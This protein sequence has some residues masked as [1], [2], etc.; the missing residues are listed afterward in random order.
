MT[1]TH[2]LKVFDKTNEHSVEA[3]VGFLNENNSITICLN[4]AINLQHNDNF[5]ITLFP[6]EWKDKKQEDINVSETD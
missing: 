4:P 3:G 6:K 2:R 1:F 5:V